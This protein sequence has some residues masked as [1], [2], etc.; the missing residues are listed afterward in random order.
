MKG[1]F[2][3]FKM[4]VV[5]DRSK[6]YLYKEVKMNTFSMR[7]Y[8]EETDFEVL[9]DFQ[10]EYTSKTVLQHRFSSVSPYISKERLKEILQNVNRF[11]RYPCI[12]ADEKDVPIGF[13]KV[14]AIDPTG[15]HRRSIQLSLWKYPE[16]TEQVLQQLTNAIFENNNVT[17]L[18]CECNAFEH[19][20][21]NALI[22]LKYE[23]VGYIPDYSYY[24][25][26]LYGKYTFIKR[27]DTEHFRDRRSVRME[28][29][30]KSS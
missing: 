15:N 2:A 9:Y 24:D 26:K 28:F 13:S 7:D 5:F 20:L 29:L 17:M 18:I 14:D 6:S 22:N 30:L 11:S 23:Q 3:D 10:M 8:N 16:L 27:R 19:H 21:Y 12:V 4:H 25:N 1:I